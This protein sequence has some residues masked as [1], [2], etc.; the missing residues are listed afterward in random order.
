V[1]SSDRLGPGEA[2]EIKAVVQTKGKKGL[3][4]KTVQVRTNDPEHPLTILKLKARIRDPFHQ[5]IGSATAL[6]GDPC[7][8]CHVERG[9]GKMGTVLFRA[10]CIMCHRRGKKAG[11]IAEMRKLPRKDLRKIISFGK[12]GT[13]MPGFASVAGGPLTEQQISSL[14]R[15]IKNR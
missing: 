12:E 8:T 15:Y 13:M 4:T 1:V 6:F 14:V 11:S 2:G 10:D 5:D 7:R 9:I 3:V